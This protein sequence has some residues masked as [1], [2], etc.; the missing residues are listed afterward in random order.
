[1]ST[2]QVEY[3]SYTHTYSNT[4][5]LFL[6]DKN[7]SPEEYLATLEFLGKRTAEIEKKSVNGLFILIWTMLIV[8]ASCLFGFGMTMTGI[9]ARGTIS[10]KKKK[11]F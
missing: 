10:S 11:I 3:D 6:Q 4:Y 5:P 9:Y 8:F 7:I 2:F 1:M